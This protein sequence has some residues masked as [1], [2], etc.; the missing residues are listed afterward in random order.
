MSVLDKLA[1]AL[2][3]PD[4]VPNQELARKIVSKRDTAAV[5]ELIRQPGSQNKR[6][7]GDCIKTLYEIGAANP[8]LIAKYYKEFGNLL[9][10]RTIV[11]SGA[12]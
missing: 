5:Q 1:T 4:E 7:Q 6:I 8:D 3:P 12:P 10:S 11:W 2:G 9:E